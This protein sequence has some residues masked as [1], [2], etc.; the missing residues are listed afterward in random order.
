MNQRLNRSE[1]TRFIFVSIAL[2]MLVTGCN[3]P[4]SVSIQIVEPKEPSSQGVHK[5]PRPP[6]HVP[7][8]GYRKTF[9]YQY[10]PTP[11]VYYEP[12]RNVYFY[13]SD[14]QWV[15]A[16]GLPSSIHLDVGEMVTL[17]L[18]TNR[19]YVEKAKHIKQVN[20]RLKGPK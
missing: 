5:Q 4:R 9:A 1:V 6:A 18:P 13:L 12:S 10:Y 15:M 2:S 3:N 14:G 7:A 16:V 17:E 8:H 19:P 20:Y 11:N